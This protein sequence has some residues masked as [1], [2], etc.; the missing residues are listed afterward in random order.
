MKRIVLE[1]PYE[2]IEARR[3]P[4]PVIPFRRYVAKVV[5]SED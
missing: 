4:K 5:D 2:R 3:P 1:Q